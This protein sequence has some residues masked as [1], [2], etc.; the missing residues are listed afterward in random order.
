MDFFNWFRSTMKFRFPFVFHLYRRPIIAHAVSFSEG[1][2]KFSPSFPNSIKGNVGG[3]KWNIFFRFIFFTSML[4][5]VYSFLFLLP[6]GAHENKRLGRVWQ[7]RTR[8]G[9]GRQGRERFRREKFKAGQGKAG[10]G[11]AD[12]SVG[13]QSK[14]KKHKPDQS[15]TL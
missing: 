8:Q 10:R 11:G 15:R 7:G 12:Q 5:I 9:K 1:G 14:E 2:G 6:S 3:K 13:K 4:T